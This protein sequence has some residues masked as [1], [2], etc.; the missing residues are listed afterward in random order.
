MPE[1]HR[2]SRFSIRPY[3][4]AQ[5]GVR[6]SGLLKGFW[7]IFYYVIIGNPQS[8]WHFWLRVRTLW[9]KDSGFR[10]PGFISVGKPFRELRG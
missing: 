7:G 3:S 9:A 6:G 2:D 5:F 4:L 10:V 1:I 8:Y